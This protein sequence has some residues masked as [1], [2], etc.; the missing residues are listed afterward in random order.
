MF[1]EDDQMDHNLIE[2]QFSG[3][4]LNSINAKSFNEKLNIE[5]II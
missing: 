4:S 5:Q 1:K 2:P 3:K